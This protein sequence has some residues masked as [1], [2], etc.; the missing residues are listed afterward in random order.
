MSEKAGYGSLC[1]QAPGGSL[2]RVGWAF[3]VQVGLLPSSP[4]SGNDPDRF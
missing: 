1:Q 2:K 4:L 3:F